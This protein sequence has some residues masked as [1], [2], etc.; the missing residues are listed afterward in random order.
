MSV[1]TASIICLTQPL[2]WIVA[3]RVPRT[4]IDERGLRAA[5]E[6]RTEIAGEP[7]EPPALS[8][9]SRRVIGDMSDMG[10]KYVGDRSP[11]TAAGWL[12]CVVRGGG[13]G[14]YSGVAVVDRVCVPEREMRMSERGRGGVRR[15][16]RL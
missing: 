2:S 3:S 7:E 9:E 8:E 16:P 5:L 4:G 11:S 13:M 15:A 6:R 10:R 1:Q 14:G 12:G